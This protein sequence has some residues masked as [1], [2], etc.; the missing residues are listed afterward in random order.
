MSYYNLEE[1]KLRIEKLRGILAKRGL[2]AAL[3]Y[4]DELNIANGW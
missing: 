4:Y 2:D 3:V 1:S